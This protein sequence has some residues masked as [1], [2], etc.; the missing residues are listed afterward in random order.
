MSS[1]IAVLLLAVTLTV[2]LVVVATSPASRSR[3]PVEETRGRSGLSA[4]R[5]LS[6]LTASPLVS[7]R[8]VT[9]PALDPVTGSPP[10]GLAADLEVTVTT[11][12][13]VRLRVCGIPVVPVQSSQVV[14]RTFPGSGKYVVSASLFVPRTGRRHLTQAYVVVAERVDE[15]RDLQ[16]LSQRV[17]D[18]GG[19][20]NPLVVRKLV[21]TWDLRAAPALWQAIDAQP[22]QESAARERAIWILG[23]MPHLDSV[24]R[25]IGLL[26]DKGVSFHAELALEYSLGLRGSYPVDEDDTATR[27]SKI[28]ELLAKFQSQ[29]EELRRLL[30]Q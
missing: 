11:D 23:E 26:R 5:R 30:H 10:S 1:R 25:L 2:A 20:P 17:I 24:P 19:M 6:P 8:Q 16:H 7:V 3:P 4:Q 12:D 9:P 28:A 18:P 15:E 22:N 13:W 21:A 14:R 29:E 27:E